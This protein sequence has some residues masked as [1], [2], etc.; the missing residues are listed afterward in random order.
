MNPP[1]NPPSAFGD[2]LGDAGGGPQP[3][4]PPAPPP[5]PPQPHPDHPQMHASHAPAPA[6]QQQPPQYMPT[7]P[8]FEGG[9]RMGPAHEGEFGGGERG[10]R[11]EAMRQKATSVAASLATRSSKSRQAAVGFLNKLSST[12]LPP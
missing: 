10:S 1:M 8:H 6:Q 12:L 9:A 3:P 11:R 2:L 5:Q 7:D 4:S